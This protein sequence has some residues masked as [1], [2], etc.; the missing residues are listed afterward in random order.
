[1]TIPG[2]WGQT[3]INPRQKGAEADESLSFSGQSGLTKKF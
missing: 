2:M 3:S 1:M